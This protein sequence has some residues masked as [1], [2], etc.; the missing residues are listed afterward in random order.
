MYSVRGSSFYLIKLHPILVR[1]IIIVLF[2]N[3][4]WNIINSF[5][6]FRLRYDV[7]ITLHKCVHLRRNVCSVILL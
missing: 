2:T 7:I 1:N 3:P 4:I 6:L 5:K